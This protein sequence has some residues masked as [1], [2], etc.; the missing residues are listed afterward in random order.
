MTS[1]T[2]LIT[3]ATDGLGRALAARFAKSGWQVIIHGRLRRRCDDVRQEIGGESGSRRI[4]TCVAD[5]ARLRDVFAMIDQVRSL[6]PAIDLLINNAGL[7]VEE[8]RT[9]TVDGYEMVLQ[10]NYLATYAL[11]LGLL[12]EVKRAS[13]RIVCVSSASQAPVDFRDPQYESGWEGPQ[14]YGRSK[15]AQA[16]FAAGMAAMGGMDAP[17][18]Y[19]VHPGSLMPTK[20]VLGK[21][22]VGDSLETG[23]ETV[24]RIAHQPVSSDMNGL[25]FDQHGIATAIAETYDASIQRNLLD[26]SAQLISKV[27]GSEM[28]GHWRD[29]LDNRAREMTR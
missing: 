21:Y 23:V 25:Y 10:V 6:T 4:E 28:I 29:V 24:W 17:R 2:V 18:I 3:G 27:P 15:W 12:Q 8:E 26:L 9:A 20:L 5:F 11:S 14:A 22:P 16:A 19:S 1:Q 7:G 13:G